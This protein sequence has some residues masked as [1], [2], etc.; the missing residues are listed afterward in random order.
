[1]RIVVPHDLDHDL[2]RLAVALTT[3]T[4]TPHT[5]RDALRI[6]VRAGLAPA[7]EAAGLAPTTPPTAARTRR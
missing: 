2:T 4:G 5:E 7:L 1:M 3:Q 6:V